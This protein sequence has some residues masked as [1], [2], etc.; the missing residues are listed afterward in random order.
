MEKDEV[1]TVIRYLCEKE[2][3]LKDIHEDF[4]RTFG[5]ESPCYN[6]VK[7]GLQNLSVGK[8]ALRMMKGLATPKMPRLMKMWRSFT[9]WLCVTGGQT[10]E[11]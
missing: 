7:N 9:T 5:N 6:T 1:R 8:R 11:V 4:M 2:M 10:C 3:T